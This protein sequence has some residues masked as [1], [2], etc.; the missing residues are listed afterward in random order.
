MRLSNTRT[1]VRQESSLEGVVAS[2]VP[3]C[4]PCCQG[5]A[6]RRLGASCY[7]GI[8]VSRQV[9]PSPWDQLRCRSAHPSRVVSSAVVVMGV[10]VLWGCRGH[11]RYCLAFRVLEVWL[12]SSLLLVVLEGL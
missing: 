12:L 5:K 10:L 11:L 9:G 7:G 2:V 8:A 6:S 3:G 4:I 1:D